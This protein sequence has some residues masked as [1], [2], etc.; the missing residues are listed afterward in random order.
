MVYATIFNIK[1]GV[2]LFPLQLLFCKFS[3]PSHV[4][5]GSFVDVPTARGDA[6]AARKA[7][8]KIVNSAQIIRCG[9]DGLWSPVTASPAGHGGPGEPGAGRACW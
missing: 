6:E 4:V 5:I 1:G 7:R 2:A 8:T 3:S 9:R